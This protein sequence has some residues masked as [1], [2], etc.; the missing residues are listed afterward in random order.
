MIV[1]AH[2]GYPRWLNSGADF[3]EIDVRRDARGVFILSHDE[4]KPGTKNPTLDE[5]VRAAAGRIRIQLDLKESVHELELI[6]RCPLDRIVVTTGNMESIQRIK[7]RYPEVRAGLTKQF[8]EETTADFIAL[9]HHHATE[10]ALAFCAG[11]RIP[12]WVWTVDDKR[13]M[14]R[15]MSDPRIEGIITNRPDEALKLRTARS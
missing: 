13:E 10:E 7:E 3:I 8:V 2:D 11:Y 12:V 6:E 9:D 5:V 14:R 1:S 15:F 4:P